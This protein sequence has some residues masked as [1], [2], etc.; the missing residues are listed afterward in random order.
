[1]DLDAWLPDPEL[2]TRHH[3][4]AA[5]DP[6][7]LW[8]AARALRLDQ[9]RTIGHLVRWRIPGV[10]RDQSFM[11]LLATDPFTVLEEGE[12]HSISG[13]C[14]RIWTLQ[15]DY[16]QL[17]GPEDFLAWDEPR[18]VRVVFAHWVTAGP[19][20]RATLH[21]EARVGPTDKVA[22]MR[23]RALWLA[24]SPFE[25]LIGAEALALAAAH[26]EAA[27]AARR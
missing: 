7:V 14:G 22:A 18:T 21:S 9:T 3:R 16:A 20:G 12:H 26:A 10:P 24:V 15:R 17:A 2:V 6:D 27:A 19:D 5:V 11:G 25:R 4:E 8:D 13:L 1:M 23:L